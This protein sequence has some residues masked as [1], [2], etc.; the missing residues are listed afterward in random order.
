MSWRI[1][2][3]C[4]LTLLGRPTYIWS[5]GAASSFG[6][7]GPHVIVKCRFEL[8]CCHIEFVSCGPMDPCKVNVSH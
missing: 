5:F 7:L 4:W 8:E 6:V 2:K 3:G 1:N